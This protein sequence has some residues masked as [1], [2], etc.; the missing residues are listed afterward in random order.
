L[1]AGESRCSA[2]MRCTTVHYTRRGAGVH[3][4]TMRRRVTTRCLG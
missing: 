4:G 1:T 3:C 2:A